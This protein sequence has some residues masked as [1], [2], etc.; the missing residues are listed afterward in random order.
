M[1]S[2]SLVVANSSKTAKAVRREFCWAPQIR[3]MFTS[4]H[5]LITYT[6]EEVNVRSGLPTDV[7]IVRY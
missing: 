6:N 5:T 4:F 7:D 1:N 3:Y 2:L